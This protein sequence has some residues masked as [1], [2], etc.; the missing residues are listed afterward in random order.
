MDWSYCNCKDGEDKTMP[1]ILKAQDFVNKILDISNNKKTY[2]ILGCFGAPMNE[3]N[4]KRYTS[5][6]DYNRSRAR[7]I[8]A[9]TPD[10]FGFDCVC[11]IKSVLWG[12]NGDKNKTYGGATYCSNGVPDVGAD[13]MM[14]TYCRNVSR[15]FSNIKVG[16]AVWLSGH[17]GVYIGD[18]LAVECT[19]KW[20][21]KVQITA[22][23][24]IGSKKGYNTRTWVKHGELPWIDYSSSVNGTA[25]PKKDDS[26]IE[27]IVKPND[28]LWSISKKFLG[29][30]KRYGEIV[31]LNNLKSTTII[32]NQKLKIKVK[33][34]K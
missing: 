22:V 6:N 27:Y 28:N 26:I 23:G 11:L 9:L 7:L 24:N 20:A 8:N 31:A 12:F 17:I 16:E 13:A 14:N 2:Y 4:R 5:N 25:L 3:K 15:D 30:G 10:T 19:P 21:N 32:P 34:D 33:G 1:T 18:G 29:D